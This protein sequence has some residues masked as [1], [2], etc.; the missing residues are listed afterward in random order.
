MEVE[1]FYLN[2]RTL[3]FIVFFFSSGISVMREWSM[4]ISLSVCVRLRS[5]WIQ[6]AL[7][8]ESLDE[9]QINEI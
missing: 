9:L 7:Q 3:R 6:T 8:I 2:G 5:T 1:L 4:D